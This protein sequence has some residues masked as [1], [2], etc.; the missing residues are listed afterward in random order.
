MTSL[1]VT[2]MKDIKSDH[3]W[4]DLIN[5]IDILNNNPSENKFVEC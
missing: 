2:A 3:G 4:K 1:S 5:L